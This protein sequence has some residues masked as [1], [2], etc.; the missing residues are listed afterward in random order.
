MTQVSMNCLYPHFA[1]CEWSSIHFND[2]NENVID[3]IASA[4]V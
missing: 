3:V 1:L 2:K 4:R